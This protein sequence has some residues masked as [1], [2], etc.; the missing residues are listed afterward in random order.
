MK[1]FWCSCASKQ[2]VNQR[3][4]TFYL[5]SVLSTWSRTLA[6]PPPFFP[7]SFLVTDFLTGLGFFSGAGETGVS[8]FPFAPLFFASSS[9]W[10][11]GRTP[12]A[13]IV[14]PFSNW[15]RKTKVKK[16]GFHTVPHHLEEKILIQ[17]LF[18]KDICFCNRTSEWKHNKRYGWSDNFKINMA[19]Y[20]I[21]MNT[22]CLKC[23][24]FQ[25]SAV[26]DL[27]QLLIVGDGQQDVSWCD[28]TFLVVSGCVT[29]QLQDLSYM[30]E[31]KKH[32]RGVSFCQ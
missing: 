3:C 23:C 17:N 7:L 9:G 30:G 16:G 27:V 29:C 2:I 11:L 22:T 20:Y 12:P 1:C 26:A 32:I 25:I 31:V 5:R 19:Q 8:S 28:S 21:D 18:N 13:A 24:F 14:T 6:F 10:M 4:S 15:Y